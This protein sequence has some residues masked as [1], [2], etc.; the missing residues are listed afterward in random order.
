M[1]KYVSLGAAMMMGVVQSK[2]KTHYNF[3][4][5]AAKVES[6]HRHDDVKVH[7]RDD[8]VKEH[9]VKDFSPEAKH[10]HGDDVQVEDI[11]N[12]ATTYC[13]YQYTSATFFY[14][15]IA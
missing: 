7:H 11:P 9:H 10:H 5:K 2:S 1:K 14:Q 3:E 15:V 8:D 6:H 13:L 4:E 12:V